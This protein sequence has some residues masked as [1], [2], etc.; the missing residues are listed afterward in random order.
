MMM[1]SDMKP[2]TN[3]EELAVILD[4]LDNEDPTLDLGFDMGFCSPTD[5]TLVEC[6]SAC[7]IGGWIN[8]INKTDME[9]SDAVL[10]ISNLK[11]SAALDL[12]YN[13]IAVN[14]EPTPQQGAEAIRNA[15]KFGDANWEE[16]LNG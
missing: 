10:S 1:L 16:V 11:Q 3:L 14:F 6:G 12:C 7:C 8:S 13:N 2:I 15:I 4:G 5:E 9:L